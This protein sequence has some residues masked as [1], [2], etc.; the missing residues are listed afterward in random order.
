MLA[1]AFGRQRNTYYRN[2]RRTTSNALGRVTSKKELL[3]FVRDVEKAAVRT[4][5]AQDHRMRNCLLACR[6]PTEVIALH[7]Q[8][9]LLPRVVQETFRFCMSLLELV[10]S[11]Q[12]ELDTPV[13]KDSCVDQMIRHHATELGQIRL[14]ST[15]YRMH[16]L[17]TY[18]Y[19]RNSNK[20]KYQDPSF[21]RAL[22]YSVARGTTTPPSDDHAHSDP[23]GAQAATRCKHCR[24]N[25]LHSGTTKE[26]CTLSG[27]TARKAQA[28]VAN[29]NKTQAQAAARAIKDAL[30]GNPQGNVDDIVATAQASV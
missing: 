7:L 29:L 27:L 3:Q 30:S 9:G 12:W 17:E 26:D 14:T 6:L 5:T 13:W 15:D 11:S 21:T 18:V 22:L 8:S 28:A 4:R 10:R 19:L 20:E 2:W 24:R 25:G 1:R 16:L 23:T